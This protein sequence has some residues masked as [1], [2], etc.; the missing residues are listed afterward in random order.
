[1]EPPEKAETV[2]DRAPMDLDVA[3]A[4]LDTEMT[5]DEPS[6]LYR[7]FDISNVQVPH[8]ETA[9]I[10]EVFPEAFTNNQNDDADDSLYDGS[11]TPGGTVSIYGQRPKTPTI[12]PDRHPYSY[13]VENPGQ[14][15]RA[16]L[17]RKR[18]PKPW[19]FKIPRPLLHI[20][21]KTDDGL[22]MFNI[23]GEVALERQFR[24]IPNPVNY[25]MVV[26]GFRLLMTIRNMTVANKAVLDARTLGIF[27]GRLFFGDKNTLKIFNKHF[28]PKN[29]EI[30]PALAHG[31]IHSHYNDLHHRFCKDKNLRLPEIVKLLRIL[32]HFVREPRISARWQMEPVGRLKMAKSYMGLDG[33]MIVVPPGGADVPFGAELPRCVDLSPDFMRRFGKRWPFNMHPASVDVCDLTHVRKPKRH[34]ALCPRQLQRVPPF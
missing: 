23:P 27:I 20:Y 33:K 26:R 17:T 4:N 34:V 25:L 14:V 32:E 30:V 9:T 21:E 18:V 28:L 24:Q 12:D 10:F 22:P 5:M 29:L 1:M 3:E 11:G 15:P 6:S 16:L 2:G 7:L 8:N 19:M 13:M 31:E